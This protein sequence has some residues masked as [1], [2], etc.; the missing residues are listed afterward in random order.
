MASIPRAWAVIVYPP[1]AGTGLRHVALVG[2]DRTL[3]GRDATFWYTEA[4]LFDPKT[5]GCKQ[6]KRAYH[7]ALAKE[8]DH[9]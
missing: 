1:T 6:C 9:A 7:A 2:G 4:C 8:S 5:I 3:C